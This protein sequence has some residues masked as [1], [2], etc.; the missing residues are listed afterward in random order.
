MSGAR[1]HARVRRPSPA[2]VRRALAEGLAERT[3]IFEP[4]LMVA[5]DP[6][7]SVGTAIERLICHPTPSLSEHRVLRQRQI[8]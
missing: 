1:K 8:I 3:L 5:R 7:K 4:E 6:A 2:A